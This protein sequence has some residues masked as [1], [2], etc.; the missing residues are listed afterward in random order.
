MAFLVVAGITAKVTTDNA[1]Q[2]PN[3]RVGEFTRAFNGSGRSSVRAEKR[4][5]S[6]TVYFPTQAEETTFRA[7]I[8]NGGPISCSGNALGGTV[9]CFATLGDS[10]YIKRSSTAFWRSA[11]LDLEEV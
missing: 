10:A 3:I 5:W 6:V 8:A 7:A 2:R 1:V 4:A 11:T 9:T